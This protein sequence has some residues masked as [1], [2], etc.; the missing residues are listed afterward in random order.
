MAET[1]DDRAETRTGAGRPGTDATR[2]LDADALAWSALVAHW[3]RVAQAALALPRDAAGDRWRAA[4]PH[5]IELQALAFALRD[6]A[7]VAPEARDHARDRA[8]VQIRGAAG[9]LVALWGGEPMPD[10]LLDLMADAQ[11]AWRASACPG[12]AEVVWPGPDELI[13]PAAAEP[14]GPETPGG[15]LLLMA[16]GT[17]AL[18]GDPVAIVAERAAPRFEGV[19][20]LEVRAVEEIRQLYRVFD[21]R[22]RWTGAFRRALED[23]LPAGMPVLVPIWVH[24]ERVGRFTM[25]PEEWTALQRAAGVG[26]SDPSRP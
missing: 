9:A 19:A 3:T 25:E 22:G 17:I 14:D 26:A 20:G 7:R 16:P 8:A 21:A 6:M 15:T 12:L 18:P 13:V 23:E 10:A 4:V 11:R 5:V 24:G 1:E 2:T